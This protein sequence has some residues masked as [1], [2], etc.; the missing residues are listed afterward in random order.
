[1]ELNACMH[2]EHEANTPV[3]SKR[4]DGIGLGGQ[5]SKKSNADRVLK[6]SENSLWLNATVVVDKT[7]STYRCGRKK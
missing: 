2:F 5:K 6:V 3:G 7:C 4:D 1:M